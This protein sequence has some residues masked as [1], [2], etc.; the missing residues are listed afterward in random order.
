MTRGLGVGPVRSEKSVC[1]PLPVTINNHH[2]EGQ[3]KEEGGI[4]WPPAG[5]HLCVRG[6][7]R[8]EESPQRAPVAHPRAARGY[9]NAKRDSCLPRSA[10]ATLPSVGTSCAVHPGASRFLLGGSRTNLEA[11]PSETVEVEIEPASRQLGIISGER[12]TAEARNRNA[13][14]RLR[15]ELPSPRRERLERLSRGHAEFRKH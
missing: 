9:N 2:L 15:K 5:A 12:E 7:A 8:P 3:R 6:D 11:P 13:V 4:S 10:S 14:S 1:A